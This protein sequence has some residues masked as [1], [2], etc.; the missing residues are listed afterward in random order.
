MRDALTAA[1]TAAQYPASRTRGSRASAP[2]SRA[3][4][5]SAM[6][7]TSTM[8]ASDIARETARA[9]YAIAVMYPGLIA[10][11]TS[12]AGVSAGARIAMTA[13]IGSVTIASSARWSGGYV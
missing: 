3:R 10:S 8:I 7:A 11:W 5:S 12:A 4:I 13:V 1:N 2:S 6:R 9:T